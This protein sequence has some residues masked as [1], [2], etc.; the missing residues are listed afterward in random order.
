[1]VSAVRSIAVGGR[2]RERSYP[3]EFDDLVRTL[4][5]SERDVPGYEWVRDPLPDTV[6]DLD[7][8]IEQYLAFW[9]IAGKQVA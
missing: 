8:E 6:G 4:N 2:T 5:E 7:N 9:A 3:R 1:M